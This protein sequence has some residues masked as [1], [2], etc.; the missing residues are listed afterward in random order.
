VLS[1]DEAHFHLSGYVNKQNFSVLGG[2]Q[3]S[4]TPSMTS[5]QPT[6]YCLVCCCRFWCNR[7]V[8]FWGDEETVTVNSDRYVQML[9]NF[10]DPKLNE[11]GNPAVWFQQEGATARTVRR[12]MGVLQ[13]MF[14]RRLISLRGD[15]PWPARSPDLVACDFFLWGHLKAEVDK[16]RPRTTDELKAALQH[17]IAAIPPEMTSWVMRNFRVR[18]QMCIENEIFKKR[19]K[20]GKHCSFRLWN[21]TL[22]SIYD[23]F[24]I[25][26][27]KPGGISDALWI[28]CPSVR[29]SMMLGLS[30]V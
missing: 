18:L 14:P 2:K 3:L 25:Y 19:R 6:C 1:S 11:R 28:I 12:S 7:T 4:T 23:A 16:R 17:E 24:F 8:L 22:N 29:S 9:R 15:I 10:L 30:F 26:L 13:E 21:K 27:W 5:T 20:E